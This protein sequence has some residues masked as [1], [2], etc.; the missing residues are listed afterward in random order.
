[1]DSLGLSDLLTTVC[2]YYAGCGRY[3]D[4]GKE[5]TIRRNIGSSGKRKA[6]QDCFLQSP[7]QNAFV[8]EDGTTN[9]A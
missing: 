3:K 4:E 5:F 6:T 9:S 1:M 8:T 2:G 7:A